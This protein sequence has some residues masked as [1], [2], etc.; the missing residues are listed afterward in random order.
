MKNFNFDTIKR[1][2]QELLN[3]KEGH[4]ICENGWYSCPMSDDCQNDS[5][6]RVCTC[7]A[8]TRN[9]KLEELKEELLM[10][11]ILNTNDMSEIHK[12]KKV[13]EI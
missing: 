10:M 12:E 13:Y 4:F 7:G 1:V 11:V 9:D 3:L 5:L 2:M 6:P 8:D